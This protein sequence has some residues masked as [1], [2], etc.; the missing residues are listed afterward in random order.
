[1][2]SMI[3]KIFIPKK[4]LIIRTERYE[5]FKKLRNEI[6]EN[7]HIDP[8]L[9]TIN[10]NG[11]ISIDPIPV[12]STERDSPNIFVHLDDGNCCIGICYIN[13]L[14]NKW[15]YDFS[16]V[17][18]S[19]KT[20]KL[21]ELFSSLDDNYVIE[22]FNQISEDI[23][24]KPTA[25]I[26]FRDTFISLNLFTEE[27]ISII[28]E[29]IKRYTI[30]GLRT[31]A[32]REKELKYNDINKDNRYT[33]RPEINISCKSFTYEKEEFKNRLNVIFKIYNI[34]VEM[35]SS[36]S[37]KKF[38]KEEKEL[39]KQIEINSKVKGFGSE[40]FVKNLKIKLEDLR[41]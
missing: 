18:N 27:K 4:T 28:H 41:R 33:E 31:K 6:I 26:K 37:V 16:H 9:V 29:Y 23:P 1:M 36:K 13:R 2:I 11:Y 10:K 17:T 34:L 22:V 38:N 39:L 25:A 3:E 35:N 15:K 5:A 21:Y 32:I 20:K 19:T 12:K 7:L 14:L 40:V 8:N 30:E 24:I